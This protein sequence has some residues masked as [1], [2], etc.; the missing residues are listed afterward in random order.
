MKIPNSA[1]SAHFGQTFYALLK[2]YK[3]IGILDYPLLRVFRY[4]VTEI[5]PFGYDIVI[6]IYNYLKKSKLY[7][8]HH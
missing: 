7:Y 2:F 3:S 4:K 1:Q 6:M 5:N 8:G